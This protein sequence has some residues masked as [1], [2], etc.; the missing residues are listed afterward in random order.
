ML[1]N[2]FVSVYVMFAVIPG[3]QEIVPKV[4]VKCKSYYWNKSEEKKLST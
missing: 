1:L 4:W 3:S 2:P